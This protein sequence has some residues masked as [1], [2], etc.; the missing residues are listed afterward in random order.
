MDPNYA[1]A[2]V[3]IGGAYVNAAEWYLPTREAMPKV[4][5][6]AQKALDLD[7]SLAD[8]HALMTTY[9]NWCGWDWATGEK[10]AKRAIELDPNTG[11]GAYAWHLSIN[12]RS[13]EA[14]K[15]MEIEQ[16]VNPLI[17]GTKSDLVNYI[18]AEVRLTKPLSRLV[19][20]SN[21]IRIMR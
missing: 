3:G 12:G 17:L 11:H 10:E 4:K 14:I 13:D 5:I 21:W 15:E 7:E 16:D 19:R 2:Y 20:Q 6:A 8:A 9:E 1:L 18:F